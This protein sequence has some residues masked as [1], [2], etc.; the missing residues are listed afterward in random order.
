MTWFERGESRIYYEELGSG[1]PALLLPGFTQS[2]EHLAALRVALATTYH[3]IA[4]DLPG[5]GRSL[6]QPRTYTAS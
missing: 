5:S 2:S 6:P 3:V 1:V 4:V